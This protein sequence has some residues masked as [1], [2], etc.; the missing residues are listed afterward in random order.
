MPLNTHSGLLS[1]GHCGVGGAMAH[2]VETY[3]QMLER[4]GSRQ[5]KVP[6]LAPSFM[7]MAASSLLFPDREVAGS[8]H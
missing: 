2:L 4:A 1:Y 8:D 5:V 3:D 7:E 6:D